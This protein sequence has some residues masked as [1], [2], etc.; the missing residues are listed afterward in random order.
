MLTL[1]VNAPEV[2]SCYCHPQLHVDEIYSHQFNLRQNWNIDA[3]T[4]ISFPI[5]VI[6]HIKNDSS[7]VQRVKG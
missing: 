4:L 3:L 5:T 7:R 2:A 1:I 6:K